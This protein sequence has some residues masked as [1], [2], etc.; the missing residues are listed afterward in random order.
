[1]PCE[2]RFDKASFS[3]LWAKGIP[4]DVLPSKRWLPVNAYDL[5]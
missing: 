1:M 2:L 5:L 3:H 4:K